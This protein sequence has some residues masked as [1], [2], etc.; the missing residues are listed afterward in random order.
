MGAGPCLAAVQRRSPPVAFQ[1]SC[2][3]QLTAD[4]T[5][6]SANEDVTKSESLVQVQ[7]DCQALRSIAD[8]RTRDPPKAVVIWER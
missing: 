7:C 1:C 2:L 5:D 4:A 6:I 3:D 8:A